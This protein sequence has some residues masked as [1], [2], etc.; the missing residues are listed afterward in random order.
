[1]AFFYGRDSE[2]YTIK[3]YKNSKQNCIP[4]SYISYTYFT[5]P[6][7]VNE[8]KNRYFKTSNINTRIFDN[9]QKITKSKIAFY[10]NS[11]VWGT[12]LF[13]DETIS[14]NFNKLSN[15][16]TINFGKG[17][18]NTN[19]EFINMIYHDDLKNVSK[20]YFIDGMIDIFNGCIKENNPVDHV[21]Y[22]EFK[23]NFE[24]YGY[25]WNWNL[26][27]VSK[28][29]LITATF[30][31]LFINEIKLYFSKYK[32]KKEKIEKHNYDDT[33]ICDTDQQRAEMVAENIINNWQISNLYL[34][35]K[36]IEFIAVLQPS[37]FDSIYDEVILEWVYENWNSGSRFN[38]HSLIGSDFVHERFKQIS[39]VKPYIL[40]KI[41]T[42]ED[43]CFLDSSKFIKNQKEYF[44][45]DI[46]LSP[47]GSKKFAKILINYK[48]DS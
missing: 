3:E 10:G 14:A 30:N 13:D 22:V 24:K 18:V 25:I 4:K 48:C 1:M 12:G 43:F 8:K 27:N 36:G 6:I 26:E 15:I 32:N 34:K 39:S 46:H 31:R 28:K 42:V 19:S 9:N 2:K 5:N 47:S 41:K 17:A 38:N 40:E 11:T 37:I 44:I 35:S 23:N 16:S 29:E 20:V 45:D 21:R 7:C 33:L